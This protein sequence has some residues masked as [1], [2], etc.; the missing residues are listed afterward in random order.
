MVKINYLIFIGI[1]L[2]QTGCSYFNKD[3]ILFNKNVPNYNDK[4]FQI[5]PNHKFYYKIINQDRVSII[6]YK[7]PEL[8][9]TS[10]ISTKE[11]LGIPIFDNQISLPLI[12]E[13][14]IVGLTE[15]EASLKIQNSYKKYLKYSKV[16]L[17][18]LTKRVFIMGE[19][20]NPGEFNLRKESISLLQLIIKAGDIKD[21]ANKKKVM[22]IRTGDKGI[23]NTKII[24]FTNYKSLA[25]ANR[26]LQPN[27]IVYIFPRNIDI[28][29]SQIKS[30]SPFFSLISTIMSPFIAYKAFTK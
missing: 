12:E 24:D 26:P 27:D 16:R 3:Y 2:L 28:I 15:R 11:D 6:V 7:H 4:S 21:S 14:S 17:E 22:I 20:N 29:N 18:V 9:T 10:L 25:F 30:I 1:Y 19:I 13:I 23:I 5:Y 8:S